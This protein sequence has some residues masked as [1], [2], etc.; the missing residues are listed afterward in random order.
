[1]NKIESLFKKN[2]LP[3]IIAVIQW[4]ITTILQVDRAFFVYNNENKI[5]IIIKLL[6]L[7]FLIVI[8]C[9]LNNC[10]KKIKNEDPDYKRGFQ[11]FCVHF[12]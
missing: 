11:I 2:K 7:I 9:F 8:W 5:L 1:M 6:Y 3:V 12:F 4:F 10:Y